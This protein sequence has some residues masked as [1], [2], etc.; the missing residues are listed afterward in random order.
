VFC[1]RFACGVLIPVDANCSSLFRSI[2]R[3]AHCVPVH[4][5][6]QERLI[7]LLVNTLSIKHLELRGQA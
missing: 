2:R 3:L 4:L 5:R 1:Y 7:V 6:A